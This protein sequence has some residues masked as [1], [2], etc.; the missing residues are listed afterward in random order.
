MELTP[1]H[2]LILKALIDD[3]VF[4]N[5]P[6]GSKSLCEKHDFRLSPATI[7][8][9]FHDLEEMGYIHSKHHSGGRIPTETGYRFYVGSLITLYELSVREKQRIQEEYLKNQFKLDQILEATCRILSLLSSNAGVVLAPGNTFDSLK[10]LELIHVTG[11]EILMIIVTRAGTVMHKNLFLE[12]NMS[13]ESLYKIS[14]FLNDNLKGFDLDEIYKIFQSLKFKNDAPEE[15]R[16]VSDILQT[17]FEIDKNETSE[18]YID[19]LQNLFSNFKDDESE[20]MQSLLQLVDD[21][22][23]LKEFFS[24]YVHTDGVTTFIAEKDDEQMGGFSIVATNYRMGEKRIGSM[25]I[26]GHQRMNYTKTLPLV[27]FTSKLVS[28]MITKISK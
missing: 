18:I 16:K 10:H 24:K 6:V 14:K 19:G 27:E 11:D 2:R 15:F 3:F 17:A 7:R 4:E 25:G 1:R 26:I 13:Q 9:V 12:E 20:R 28:E 21:K 22:K 23:Q 5:K 8:N